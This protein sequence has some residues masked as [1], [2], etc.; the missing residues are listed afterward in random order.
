MFHQTSVLELYPLYLSLEVLIS[1][2]LFA[3]EHGVKGQGPGPSLT[4]DTVLHPNLCVVNIKASR[5]C[6]I[7][8]TSSAFIQTTL[9]YHHFPAA[10]SRSTGVLCSPTYQHPTYRVVLKSEWLILAPTWIPKINIKVA[11][12]IFLRFPF[13]YYSY[14]QLCPSTYDKPCAKIDT[15]WQFPAKFRCYR[16]SL[17]QTS[18]ARNHP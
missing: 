15:N 17:H 14:Y 5:Y 4:M 7:Y 8:G 13:Y 6:T 10:H 12:L 3:H 9:S 16:P 18:R 2:V 11:Q 1:G